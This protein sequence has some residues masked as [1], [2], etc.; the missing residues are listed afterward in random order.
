MRRIIIVVVPLL[1]V[2][3]FWKNDFFCTEQTT[4]TAI[5]SIAQLYQKP[6]AQWPAPQIDKSV[7]I[8]HELAPI[9]TDTNY[10][11]SS[12][13]PKVRL[14]KLLFFDARL[15]G[16]DQISCSHCHH[17]EMGF[18]T[19]TEK[20][21]GHNHLLGTR[22]APSLLN[23]FAK[24]HFFWDA[25]ASTLEEQA[26]G[27]IAAHHEMNMPLNKLPA[28]LQNIKIYRKLFAEAFGS[29][30]IKEQYILEALSEF[31]RTLR[32]QPSR[33]DAFALGN[34]QALSKEEIWGLHL[35]RTKARCMNCH[36]GT[37]FTDYGL[38]N[39]GISY[40]GREQ[41]DLGRYYI[42]KQAKDMGLFVTPSLRDL[43]ITTPYMHNGL[44]DNLTGIVN[45]YNSGMQMNNPTALEKQTDSL[46]PSASSLLLP[47]ELNDLEI[48][49]LVKFLESLS[50]T[51]YKMDIPSIPTDE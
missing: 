29:S 49:A 3:L 1:A 40:Y 43:L 39:I 31:Q 15:S 44:F 5:D 8:W 48:Q 37:Y 23:V 10:Y 41:E 9:S 26:R 6:I 35:F 2:L 38:H 12:E 24:P 18:T 7:A 32:S 16:S 33:F 51:R 47:L 19:H 17:P 25:R 20:S 13:Q 27:P 50:S 21:R 28:K 22:N 36:H 11:E 46:Y 45:M 4:Y 14:G 30:T 42:T 34:Y